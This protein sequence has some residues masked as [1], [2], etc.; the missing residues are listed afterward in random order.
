MMGD[1]NVL[2]HV[3]R[4]VLFI[5]DQIDMYRTVY[6]GVSDMNRM[7]VHELRHMDGARR[8]RVVRELP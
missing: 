4:K 2:N 3:V 5:N 1:T 7:L 8:I 6:G